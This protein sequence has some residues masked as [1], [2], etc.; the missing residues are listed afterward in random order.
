MSTV[1]AKGMVTHYHYHERARVSSMGSNFMDGTVALAKAHL[2]QH[3]P[4]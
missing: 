3:A 4:T 2:Q 1:Q